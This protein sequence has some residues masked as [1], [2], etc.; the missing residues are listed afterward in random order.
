MLK[1]VEIVLKLVTLAQVLIIPMLVTHRVVT[2][3]ST[4]RTVQLV[5]WVVYT[6]F[7][8]VMTRMLV[9]RLMEVVERTLLVHVSQMLD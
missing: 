2:E 3:S 7:F 6:W 8:L 1:W 9:V 5:I 4:Y